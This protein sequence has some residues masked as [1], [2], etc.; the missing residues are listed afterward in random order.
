MR[1]QLAFLEKL[2][3][4]QLALLFVEKLQKGQ[5]LLLSLAKIQQVL[6]TLDK[7]QQGV[8][9][10]LSLEILVEFQLFLVISK[11]LL[12]LEQV[13]PSFLQLEQLVF[14]QLIL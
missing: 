5:R 10:L 9:L 12:A 4:Q 7:V 2:L 1:L 11:P 14:L 13:L 3:E 6:L 8:Q